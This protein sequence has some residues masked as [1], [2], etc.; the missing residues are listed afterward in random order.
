MPHCG[1]GKETAMMNY[2]G[3]DLDL[4]TPQTWSAT[5]ADA[6]GRPMLQQGIGRNGPIW[7]DE[8]VLAACN[9]AFD[10]A[11]AH[12]SA[13]VRLEHLL[14]ALTRIDPAAEI[15]EANGVRVGP[16]RRDTAT[17]IAS[18][19]PIGLTNGKAMPRRSDELEDVLRAASGSAAR[20]N[21]PA[22]VEDVLHVLANAMP[23]IQALQS[24]NRPAAR[25]A[26]GYAEVTPTMARTPYTFDPTEQRYRSYAAPE[27]APSRPVR[28][29]Y[30][31]TPVDNIQNSRLDALEQ[32]V[33]ALGSDLQAERKVFGSVLNDVQREIGE[34]RNDTAR[35]LSTGMSDRIPASLSDRLQSLE[36]AVINIRPSQTAD[37]GPLFERLAALERSLHNGLQT[38]AARASAGGVDL[39]PVIERLELIEEAV[40]SGDN[41]SPSNDARYTALTEQLAAERKRSA[42]AQA[43]LLADM[44][45]IAT[46]M[47]TDVSARFDRQKSE[48]AVAILTPLTD[49]VNSLTA[50]VEGRDTDVARDFAIVANRMEALEKA[51]STATQSTVALLQQS[52]KTATD[53]QQSHAQELV[54][55]HDALM[56]LNSNQ[57]TL[58]GS[59][60]QWRR[61]DQGSLSTITERLDGVGSNVNGFATRLAGLEKVASQPSDAL[62]ALSTTVDN[63]HRVTVQRY[64][65]RNRFFYWLFGTDDWVAASW[66]SQAT[67]IADELCS[68][69]AGARI[70]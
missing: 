50:A 63:M 30:S 56:K 43:S 45:A 2:R 46:S 28:A 11:L 19:I 8:I 15:L 49:R 54:E 67:R 42:E 3:E 65:R 13:E 53:V 64:Y 22:N 14:H 5:Q 62:A 36:N 52:T 70:A 48:I 51:S 6:S 37:L 44:K 57:H 59:I 33:R 32:M 41:Q 27:P 20:Q 18:E 47:A 9:H 69:K 17:V 60:E 68:V 61:D 21:A 24:V 10:V 4:R 31:S 40:L 26:N 55:V 12:R 25:P 58:A 29:E 7:V 66:P 38:L 1:S 34:H 39:S 35:L 16:L 23:E